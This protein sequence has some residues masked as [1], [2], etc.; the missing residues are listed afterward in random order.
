MMS[1]DMAEAYSAMA[2]RIKIKQM[3]LEEIELD[4]RLRHARERQ[5]PAYRQA[6][7]DSERLNGLLFGNGDNIE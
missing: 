6:Q 2:N 3:K 5:T 1:D 7:E 4:E